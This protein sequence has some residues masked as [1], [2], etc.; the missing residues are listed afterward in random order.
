MK[1]QKLCNTFTA[2]CLISMEIGIL[3]HIGV[4]CLS[5]KD[6]GEYILPEH[7][8]IVLRISSALGVI[9]FFAALIAS[10]KDFGKE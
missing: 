10:P 9:F 6:F 1:K 8:K 2:L 4:F 3:Y 5:G 7:V